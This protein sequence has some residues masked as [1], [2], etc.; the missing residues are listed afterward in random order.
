MTKKKDGKYPNTKRIEVKQYYAYIR[1][2][3]WAGQKSRNLSIPSQIDQ[4]NQYTKHNDGIEVVKFY[5]EVHS[6]YKGKRPIFNEMLKDLKKHKHIKWVIIMKR[7]RIS[8]NPDDYL[9][10]QKVRGE[11]SPMD[12]ISVTEPMINSYLGRY[13]I[14]DLQNRSILYS[15]ELS[16][17]VKL[18]MRKKLQMGGFTITP[19]FWYK[20]LSGYL[21]ADGNKQKAEIVKYVFHT[22]AKW[23]LGMKELAKAVRKKFETKS[24]SRKHIER[25][26]D[27]SVYYGVY[28]KKWIL[29]NEEYLFFGASEPWI[30]IEKYKLKHIEPLITKRLF[31]KCQ[32][33]KSGRNPHEHKRT[34]TAK[35][36]KILQ[37]TCGRKLI[38]DDKRKTLRYVYCQKQKSS[39]FPDNCYER[40]TQLAFIDKKIEATIKGLIPTPNI[41]KK[42]IEY[43]EEDIKTFS[44]SKD[45]KLKE[46]LHEIDTLQ[47]KLKKLTQNFASGVIS[48]DVF[49]IAS[50]EINGNVLKIKDEI[51]GL[52]DK[53]AYIEAS[54]KTISFINLLE[55][56]GEK[57]NVKK[58][59]IRCSRLY[60]IMFM[61][62]LNV[63]IWDRNMKSYLLL[64]PFSF[65][66]LQEKSMWQGARELNP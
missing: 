31:D 43:I 54:N 26:L 49:V 18:W 37:C 8:R 52:E 11:D 23:K 27:C 30:F 24:F 55:Y 33:I 21:I 5:E 35:Y 48:N 1:M 3:G 63:V 22:Y 19:P 62:Y 40:T 56:Y 57:L 6:A 16:F 42:M 34:G 45:S 61:V 38:R 41:K 53:R 2:S 59:S 10:F 4:I 20:K 13:M 58:N 51:R 66:D 32:C 50:E 60:S 12:V 29:N 64:E 14:R 65:W 25:I 17:R 47:T 7:D 39:V 36:P 15:E 46:R 28:I 44:Q 9:K